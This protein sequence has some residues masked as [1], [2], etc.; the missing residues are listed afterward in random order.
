MPAE[1]RSLPATPKR[2]TD[3]RNKGQV[4]RS[5]EITVAVSL[6]TAWLVFHAFGSGMASS[7]ADLLTSSYQNLKQPDLTDVGLHAFGL[8]TAMLMGKILLPIIGALILAGL[9]ANVL[10]VGLHITPQ[11]A[12]PQLSRINPLS[13]VKR[14]FS[15]RSLEELVKS[16]LKLA[17]VAFLCYKAISDHMGDL[18]QL[19]GSDFHT[20]MGAINDI[21]MELLI[22]VGLAYLVLALLDFGFQRWQFEKD[23]R[24][25]KQELK[26][27]MRSQELNEQIRGRIRSLQRQ[28]ARQRMMQRIPQAD[29]IITNPTHY[30]V[31][32]KYD[33][34]KM[35]A[36]K[37]VAKGQ[38]LLA[39]QIKSIARAH[40]VPLVENKPLAQAL[41]R[42]VEVDQEIPR[43]LYKA[44]AEVL[45]FIYRLKQ[46]AS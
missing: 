33:A 29:V 3:A 21:A 26:E 23:L 41:Y 32:L 18:L 5:P 14:L 44:T 2:R 37:V 17:L 27:E 15:V 19:S 36:P 6:L 1:E 39:E 45:A 9:V 22:K 20:G 42:A 7:L 28:L 12:R 25:T 16:L 40:G 4:A 10:Q 8:H 30:A 31:A 24:M 13:G 34:E 46:R 38:R 43:E 11:A 35:A